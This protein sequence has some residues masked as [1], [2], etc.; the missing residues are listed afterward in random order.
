MVE[1]GKDN[2]KT[3]RIVIVNRGINE[4]K[5]DDFMCCSVTYLAFR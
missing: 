1:K 2:V 5:V 4:K 3:D